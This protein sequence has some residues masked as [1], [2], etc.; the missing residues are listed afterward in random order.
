MG[1]IMIDVTRLLDFSVE[2]VW[3][4]LRDFSRL[5]VLMPEISH[6]R[7][8]PH[9]DGLL[10]EADCHGRC[11]LH[12]LLLCD[13]GEHRLCYQVLHAHGIDARNGAVVCLKAQN[14]QCNR[15]QL[16]W[17]L[18]LHTL[19]TWLPDDSAS[20]FHRHASAVID[21]NIDHLIR[22]LQQGSVTRTQGA[23]HGFSRH[24]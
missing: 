2:Q 20:V 10:R 12:Q 21:E 15:C 1:K 4:L 3:S 11:L 5:D 8:R 6:L 23:A 13:D 18:R 22:C 17:S 14:A 24:Q 9:Q 7:L 19:P 16:I